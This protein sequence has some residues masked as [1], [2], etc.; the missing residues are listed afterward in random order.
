[1]RP[2]C[3]ASN[4]RACSATTSGLWLGSIT[5]PEPTRIRLVCAA[6]WAISTGGLP[7][8]TPGTARTAPPRVPPPRR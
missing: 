1:M 7:L 6:I 5:P 4:I 2:G 8:A 3:N